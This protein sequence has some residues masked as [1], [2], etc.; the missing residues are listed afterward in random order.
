M[1][2]N[3]AY[4]IIFEIIGKDWVLGLS[5]FGGTFLTMI[6]YTVDAISSVHI[7]TIMQ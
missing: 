4:G 6:E 1:R 5:G 7:F 3:G 2:K